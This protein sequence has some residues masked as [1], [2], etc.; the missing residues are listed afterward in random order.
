M[1]AGSAGHGSRLAGMA[2]ALGMNVG[3]AVILVHARRGARAGNAVYTLG[4]AL[5]AAVGFA[6]APRVAVSGPEL[7]LLAAFGVLTIGLAMALYMAGARR[8]PAAE[9]GLISMLDV[10]SGPGLVWLI[11]GEDPGL[12]TVAGGA[13]VV[14]ALLWHLAPDVTRLLRPA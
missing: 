6:L 7:A 2:F 13:V 3:V 5:S 1:V 8:I 9:V 4:T 11:F 14:S 12:P 10:A